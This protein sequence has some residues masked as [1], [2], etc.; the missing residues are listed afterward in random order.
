MM[1][2]TAAAGAQL[3]EQQQLLFSRRVTGCCKHGL[4][5]YG[6]VSVQ[7]GHGAAIY[8][9]VMAEWSVFIIFL[10]KFSFPSPLKQLKK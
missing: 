4:G 7:P 2:H 10:L 3:A 6:K 5:C 8:V 9:P 1:G